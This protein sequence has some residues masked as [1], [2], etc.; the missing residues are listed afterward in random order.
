MQSSIYIDLNPVA[1]GIAK[2]P[3]SSAHTSIKQRVEHVQEQGRAEDLQAAQAGSVAGSTAAAG[4]EEG[5]WLCPVEDR[6]RLDSA[7]E[8]MIEGF[9]LGNYVLLV[10]Y[11]GRLFR[12]GKAVGSWNENGGRCTGGGEAPAGGSGPKPAPHRI[13][14]LHR[15]S[16]RHPGGEGVPVVRPPLSF[17]EPEDYSLFRAGMCAHA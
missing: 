10:E 4:L 11:T 16:L 3:E 5:L 1:A 2:V 8:G 17:H 12:E 6:R 7:R 13:L 9:S 15:R 14:P